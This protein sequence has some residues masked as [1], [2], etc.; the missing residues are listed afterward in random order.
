MLC[1][2]GLSSHLLC[3]LRLSIVSFPLVLGLVSCCFARGC[4]AARSKRL[5]HTAWACSTAR[6]VSVH[7]VMSSRQKSP[8][9]IS[10]NVSL[11]L[12]SAEL[13]A[14]C[15]RP[16]N[17]ETALCSQLSNPDGDAGESDTG[18]RNETTNWALPLKNFIFRRV[19]KP[20]SRF[21]PFLREWSRKSYGLL[22][23]KVM[24]R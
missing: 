7:S 17:A 9:D 2:T 3:F 21:G 22:R 24:G 11:S 14:C 18:H 10:Q 5:H 8:S 15:S 19:S 4:T 16:R 23:V 6:C 20:Y 1:Y 13:C 12:S